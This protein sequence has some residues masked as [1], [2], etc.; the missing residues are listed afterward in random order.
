MLLQGHNAHA[1]AQMKDAAF[2]G[3]RAVKITIEDLVI[4]PGA[5]L[6]QIAAAL[7]LRTNLVPKCKGCIKICIDAFAKAL[8]V[9]PK[10]H[11]EIYGCDA[12]DMLLMLVKES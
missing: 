10:T 3:L 8:L 6:F 7:H 2:D 12:Q 11:D 5:G 1:I 4:A 9:M